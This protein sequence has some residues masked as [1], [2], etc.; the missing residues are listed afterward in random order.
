MSYVPLRKK[1]NTK[2]TFLGDNVIVTFH[3]TDIVIFNNERIILNSD[4]WYTVTTKQRMNQTSDEFG[5]GFEIS[6][7]DFDW[8]VKTQNKTLHY[9]DGMVFD[10]S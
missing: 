2:I 4:N 8:F 6:Q 1:G 3:S 10:R 7:R 9:Y 5:L